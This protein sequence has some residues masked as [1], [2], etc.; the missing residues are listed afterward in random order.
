DAGFSASLSDETAGVVFSILE[1][2]ITNAR[3]HAQ[4]HRV[5]VRLRNDQQTF[6]AEVE[7]DGIGFDVAAVEQTYDQRGSLGLINMRERAELID[8]T[9]SIISSPGNG[10][11]V[12][13]VAPLSRTAG[14]ARPAQK[15]I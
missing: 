7:D 2:A 13:L 15:R 10:T 1:E 4:A 5:V 8:G 12:V 3:K 9:L 11:R 14:P 6:M